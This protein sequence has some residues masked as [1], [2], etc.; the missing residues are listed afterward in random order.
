VTHA[1]GDK[2]AQVADG[3]GVE[4]KLVEILN[5]RLR[6]RDLLADDVGG[7]ASGNTDVTYAYVFAA[8]GVPAPAYSLEPGAPSW[9]SIN[10]GTGLVSG[11]F[12]PMERGF[13]F[14]YPVV[15]TNAVGSVTAGPFTV[16]LGGGG[17]VT[18]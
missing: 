11:E 8:S 1:S 2:S 7:K 13:D 17:V 16:H 9:L 4:G 3:V 6:S 18:G 10:A 15:A 5:P 14:S 12:G